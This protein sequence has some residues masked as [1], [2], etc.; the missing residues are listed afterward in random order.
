ME[1]PQA[2][3][4]LAHPQRLALLTYLAAAGGNAFHRRDE[5]F[6]LLWPDADTERARNTLALLKRPHG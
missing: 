3:F 5:L 2:R 6:A 1:G 4:V